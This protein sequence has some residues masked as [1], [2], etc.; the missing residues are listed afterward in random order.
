MKKINDL[1][2]FTGKGGVDPVIARVNKVWQRQAVTGIPPLLNLETT[3]TAVHTSVPH[4]SD[5]VGATG[6]FLRVA[7]DDASLHPSP[8][9]PTTPAK[10][11]GMTHETHDTRTRL[12]G[13]RLRG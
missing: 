8:G 6:Y 3:G 13:A 12:C 5:V 10:T 1:V 7:I 4:K 9:S 11:R 2:V